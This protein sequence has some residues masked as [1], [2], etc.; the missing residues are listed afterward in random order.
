MNGLLPSGR[1]R[2][3]ILMLSRSF[4][5]RIICLQSL[6][7]RNLTIVLS[8]S[9]SLW[10]LSKS[11]LPTDTLIASNIW[12]MFSSRFCWVTDLGIQAISKHS[13]REYWTF[14]QHY[15]SITTAFFIKRL[16]PVL[17]ILTSA[18]SFL[19]SVFI[20]FTSSLKDSILALVSSLWLKNIAIVCGFLSF[21]RNSSVYS[22]ASILWYFYY[23]E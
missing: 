9:Q 19:K 13:L 20:S 18:S 6:R 8:L 7:R 2:L 17:A 5:H 16:L 22:W 15:C 14:S 4:L 1:S 12:Q 21:C 23:I 11:F 3:L 10:Q